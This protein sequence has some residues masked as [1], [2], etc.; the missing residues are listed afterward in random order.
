MLPCRSL[1]VFACISVFIVMAFSVE[2]A[3]AARV[4]FFKGR[5]SALNGEKVR[6][7]RLCI[8]ADD[9][10]ILASIFLA[11]HKSKNIREFCKKSEEQG[12]SPPPVY[13]DSE[14]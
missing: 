8:V 13:T 1:A 3:A 6:L 12:L 11:L 10:L 14:V 5:A 2:A 7:A 4:C 9:I